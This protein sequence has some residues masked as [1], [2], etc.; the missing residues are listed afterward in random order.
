MQTPI[1]FN[2]HTF[3]KIKTSTTQKSSQLV[4][5]YNNVGNKK[6][7]SNINFSKFSYYG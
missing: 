5:Y 3:Q 1:D 6:L 4:I 7:R 2:T